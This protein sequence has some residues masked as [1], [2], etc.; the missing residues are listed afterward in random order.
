MKKKII[1]SIVAIFVIFI[2]FTVTKTLLAK[3][4]QP[5]AKQQTH[6]LDETRIINNL[7]SAVKIKTIS[8]E[9]RDQIDYS[10]FD[11]FI[12]FL[13]ETYPLVHENLSLERI[14][15]YSL[16]YRWEGTNP[17]AQPIGLAAHYDVVPVLKGTEND[18]E[19]EAFSGTITE[20]FVWGRGTL[21]DKVGVIGI[22]EAAEQLVK[23]GYQ[24]PQDIY[25][26]FGH[27]EEIGGDEGAAKITDYLNEQNIQLAYVMDEGG[28]IV[29]NMVPGIKAPVGV[30]GVAEKGMADVTL[31]TTG[32]GGH[33][34]QPATITNVGRI[35]KAIAK[36]E[37]Q[38][39]KAH[40]DG[41]TKELFE[42]VA[43]EM[44]F[45]Y[46]YVFENTWL[47][48]PVI[49]KILL[50]KPATA[51]V[52]RSTIAP[53]IF[54]AGEKA[55]VLPEKAQAN[56]NV[57]VMPQDTLK[58]LQK[59]IEKIIDDEAIEVT[60][61]GNEASPVSSTSNGAFQA[62]Q[63]AAR[64]TYPDAIIA[65]YIMIAGSDAKHYARAADD[66]YRF[67]PIMMEEDGLQKMHGTNERITK[68]AMIKA[69]A[70]YMTLLQET[71]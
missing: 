11:K 18:W 9:N 15:E 4:K 42:F 43:P 50:G 62:I 3:S 40:F 68:D 31:T 71:K 54:H 30:I 60:V 5:T 27:D 26:L 10:E 7:S 51:A 13:A 55:N 64:D 16:I 70:F 17:K 22:L 35:S 63:Q 59:D 46:K 6:T 29:T 67:L 32:S 33:S 25:L 69:V 21:D 37:E 49:T 47:F 44:S 45:G 12:R 34:S 52:M 56:I 57:R 53:T 8:Y 28:A 36:L 19:E 24:P 14:N 39:F 65:P 2:G 58:S 38:Q 41:P 61:E 66:T 23:E 48:Q 20:E 1:I